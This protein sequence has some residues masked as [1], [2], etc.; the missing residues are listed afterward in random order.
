[1][2]TDDGCDREV[3]EWKNNDMPARIRFGGGGEHTP[4]F[5]MKIL[6]KLTQ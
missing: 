1:M 4:A 2:M 6:I 5:Q 3:D